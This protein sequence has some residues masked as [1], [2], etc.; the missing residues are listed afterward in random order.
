MDPE[1]DRTIGAQFAFL[2]GSFARV[3][4]NEGDDRYPYRFEVDIPTLEGNVMGFATSIENAFPQIQESLER[5]DRLAVVAYGVIVWANRDYA[6]IRSGFAYASG[7]SY[8]VYD[9]ED[10]PLAENDGIRGSSENLLHAA[11]MGRADARH[12]SV[13][14]DTDGDDHTQ[15]EHE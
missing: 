8:L 7:S 2:D 6:V 1:T 5:H 10:H 12:P 11:I 9:A 4:T 15:A 14:P 13:T 3:L